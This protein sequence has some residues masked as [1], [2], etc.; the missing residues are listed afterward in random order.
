[1]GDQKVVR[2]R[3][4]L[5]NTRPGVS[6]QMNELPRSPSQAICIVPKGS[7]HSCEEIGE[8]DE[9]FVLHRIDDFRHLRVV[10]P[11]RVVLVRA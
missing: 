11:P 5:N 6:H 2:Q 7:L 9:I 10:A 4:G 8:N 1:M 3:M